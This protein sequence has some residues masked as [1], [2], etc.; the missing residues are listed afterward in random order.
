MLR[1][2]AHRELL[3]VDLAGKSR[4]IAHVNKRRCYNSLPWRSFMEPFVDSCRVM[5]DVVVSMMTI[6]AEQ[7]RIAIS[8]RTKAGLQRAIRARKDGRSQSRGS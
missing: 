8:D 7:E 5:C 2:T 3:R 4:F 6:L 1:S